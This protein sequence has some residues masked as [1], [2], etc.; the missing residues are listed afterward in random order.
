MLSEISQ[1]KTDTVLFHSYVESKQQ[2]EEISKIETD[3]QRDSR[4]TA[5]GGGEEVR[6]WRDGAKREK[7]SWTWTTLW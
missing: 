2:T 6:G 3:S 4:M 7:D 1:R 5:K